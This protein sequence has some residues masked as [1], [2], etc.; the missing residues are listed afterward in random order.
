ML[1]HSVVLFVQDINVSKRF[2]LSLPGFEIEHDFGKNVIFKGGV[3][4]WEIAPDHEIAEKTITTAQSN[5]F[6]MYFEMEKPETLIPVLE[7][8]NVRFLHELKEEPWG[9]RTI[10]FFDPDNH[11]VEVGEPLPSFIKR[12]HDEGMSVEAIHE[13]SGVPF[14]TIKNLTG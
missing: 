4:I 13:K 9:Q 3:T 8:L 1:F 6:E 14:E 10:R 7:K 12:M 11:L 2:Y 5:R